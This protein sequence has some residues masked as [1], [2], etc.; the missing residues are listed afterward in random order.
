[1]KQRWSSYALALLPFLATFG[2]WQVSV[3]LARSLGCVVPSKAPQPCLVGSLNVEPL[4]GAAA[5]WGMLLWIP[6]LL[7]SAL[8]LGALLARRL[9]PPWGKGNNASRP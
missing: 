5:W 6:G 7:I 8:W 4:L 3:L 1:V 2:G 9:P